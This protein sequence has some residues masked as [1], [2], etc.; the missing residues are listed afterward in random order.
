[1]D[2]SD[3]KIIGMLLRDSRTPLSEMAAALGISQPAVQKRIGKLKAGGI[4]AGSTIMLNTGRM[5]WKRAFLALNA[6]KAD[7]AGMLAALQKLPFVRG[8]Y[9]ATGPYAIAVELLGPVGIVNAVMAH[10]AGMKGVGDCCP[11][12]LAERV[13]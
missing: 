4:I 5:G 12:S 7:Y 9:Q 13:A 6:R 8:V 2:E 3:L 11:V 10:V 1:M